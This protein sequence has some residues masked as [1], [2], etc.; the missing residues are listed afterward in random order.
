MKP[1]KFRVV[2]VVAL[3]SKY[4]HFGNNT[5]STSKTTNESFIA[6]VSLFK[7]ALKTLAFKSRAYVRHFSP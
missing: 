2:N 4:R 6:L 7:V 3:K 5:P 1:F